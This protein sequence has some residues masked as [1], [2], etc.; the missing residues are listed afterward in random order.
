MLEDINSKLARMEAS[1]SISSNSKDAIAQ[2]RV[3]GRKTLWPMI[4]PFNSGYISCPTKTP[5]LTHE[6]YFEECGF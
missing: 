6:V 1:D 2:A 5:G 4:E 3:V